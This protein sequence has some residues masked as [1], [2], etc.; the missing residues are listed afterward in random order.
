[1]TSSAVESVGT[2]LADVGSQIA[3]I[4]QRIAGLQTLFG[5]SGG[6]FDAAL[7]AASQSPDAAMSATGSGAVDYSGAFA[8]TAGSDAASVAVQDALSQL[9]VPYQWGGES[10]G[11]DFDCS[12]LVQWAYGKAGISLPRVAADQ[13][14]EGVAVTAA[15][16]QPGD[17]VFFGSPIHHVGIYLGNGKMVDAPYTGADVRIESVDLSSCTAIRRLV[18]PASS[19]L[20]GLPASA[21]PYLDDIQSAAAQA[22][23]SPALV[24]AVAWQESNFNP[25]ATSSAGAEGLMQLMP[26]TAAGLGADPTDPRQNLAAGA[27]YLAN[28]LH[29]FDGRL[30]LALAAYNAGPNAVRQAG[31][32]PDYPQT[33]AY[34]K[35]V[36]AKLAVIRSSS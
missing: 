34:V 12:G 17:L 9:G 11:H 22:G 15:D 18:S 10:P 28:Q 4:Q 33:Q 32:V 8:N 27:K 31:G 5:S 29:A 25:S 23:I 19:T 1:M 14:K 16:A 21:K 2:A 7:A 26:A 30:D 20:S 24:A 36:L 35:S 6:S 13:A 3:A